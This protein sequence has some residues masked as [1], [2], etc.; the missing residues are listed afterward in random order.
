MRL[1]G[2][3][4]DEGFNLDFNDPMTRWLT[5]ALLLLAWLLI[6]P[7]AGAQKH[8]KGTNVGAYV[9]Y[10]GSPLAHYGHEGKY[11]LPD[12]TVTPGAVNPEIIADRSRDKRLV[13]GVEVNICAKD[14]RTGP[15]RH[16][17]QSMKEE[18]CREYAAKDCPDP[19][20]GEVDHVIPLEIGGED[21]LQNLWW[22]RSPEYHFKDHALEDKLPKLICSGKM[23]LKQAQTCIRDNWVECVK[24]IGTLK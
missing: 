12:K 3:F 6:C 20:K 16:T 18:V 10:S 22:Q 13:D 2:P 14:F 19:S 21:A 5:L 9:Y 8:S 23:T 24:R 1:T 11:L 7:F 15:F 17:T 4:D